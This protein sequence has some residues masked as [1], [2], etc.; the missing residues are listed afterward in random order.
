MAT[1]SETASVVEVDRIVKVTRRRVDTVLIWLGVVTT[2]V[3]VIAG[4]LLQWGNNFAEDRVSDELSAQKIS[5]P[6]ED[7]LIA[8]GRDDLVK[9]ADQQV[10]T[11]DHA[12]SYASFIAGHL[13]GIGNGMTFSELGVPEQA[14]NAAV[15]EAIDSDAPTDEIAALEA[16]AATITDQRDTVFRGEML[17][18]AL[19]TTYAWSVIGQIA[20]IAA[21][22]AFLAAALMFG[23]VVTGQFHLR[24]VPR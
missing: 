13:E 2:A 5:F 1:V 11:G 14:A 18:G 8:Q 12:E 21:I 9:Y 4:G 6:S 3:L 22:V 17:R 15:A 23:L 19:L 7:S 24:K 16:E 20:G 10:S